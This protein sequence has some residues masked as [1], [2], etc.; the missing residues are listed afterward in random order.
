MEWEITFFKRQK[1]K[2]EPAIT[3]YTAQ[4]I[5]K[6]NFFFR[7]FV[8]MKTLIGFKHTLR[9]QKSVCEFSLVQLNEKGENT[10]LKTLNSI[11]YCVNVFHKEEVIYLN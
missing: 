7:I 2:G 3:P 10:I 9:L 5:K 11:Y 4:K 6:Q 8:K 1:Y